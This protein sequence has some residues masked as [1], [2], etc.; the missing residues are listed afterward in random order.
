MRKVLIV[1]LTALCMFQAPMLA[2]AGRFGDDGV[3]TGNVD[4]VVE[5]LFA[6]HPNGGQDLIDAIS[7]MVLKN[8][9]R[10]DDI[11]FFASTKG[12]SA[13]QSAAGTGMGQALDVLTRAC[14]EQPCSLP[15]IQGPGQIARALRLTKNATILS[16]ASAA[17]GGFLTITGAFIPGINFVV[18]NKAGLQQMGLAQFCTG[19]PC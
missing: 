8:P 13:Q 9:D 7:A 16:A 4:N 2:Q 6:K 5:N 10:A 19:S 12:N 3:F 15:R 1:A 18:L 14:T 17:S 11:A